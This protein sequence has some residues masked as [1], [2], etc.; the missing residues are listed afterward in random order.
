M[1]TYQGKLLASNALGLKN[2]T[3]KTPMTGNSFQWILLIMNLGETLFFIQ[4]LD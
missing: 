1:W 2:Y 4:I 3:T